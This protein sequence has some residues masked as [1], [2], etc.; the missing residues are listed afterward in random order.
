MEECPFNVVLKK[1]GEQMK[2]LFDPVYVDF[3]IRQSLASELKEDPKT[4]EEII[5]RVTAK[6]YLDKSKRENDWGLVGMCTGAIWGS[7]YGDNNIGRVTRVCEPDYMPSLIEMTTS[8]QPL[9]KSKGFCGGRYYVNSEELLFLCTH[10]KEETNEPGSN[11]I[12]RLDVFYEGPENIGTR[13]SSLCNNMLEIVDKDTTRIL[14]LDEIFALLNKKLNIG[15]T[16]YE[17]KAEVI[18]GK[19]FH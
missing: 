2:Y 14:S 5:L 4:I 1:Y 8:T 16:D 15:I 9:K 12:K 3:E 18:R 17:K 6:H 19:L 7:V 11:S 10:F 13:P